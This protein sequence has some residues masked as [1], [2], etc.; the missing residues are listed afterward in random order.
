MNKNLAVWTISV[1]ILFITI[2]GALATDQFCGNTTQTLFT[3]VEYANGSM[4][5]SSTVTYTLWNGSV[6]NATNQGNGY[7]NISITTPAYGASNSYFYN[8]SSTNPTA[9]LVD[10][11]YVTNCTLQPVSQTIRWSITPNS[12]IYY[13]NQTNASCN[14]DLFRNN[15]NVAVLENNIYTILPIGTHNYSCQLQGN[16]TLLYA[17]HNETYTVLEVPAPTTGSSYTWPVANCTYGLDKSLYYLNDTITITFSCPQYYLQTYTVSWNDNKGVM[18]H[19]EQEVVLGSNSVTYTPLQPMKGIATVKAGSK[20]LFTLHFEV[21]S[22]MAKN[23][24]YLYMLLLGL[25]GIAFIY[26]LDLFIK[27]DQTGRGVLSTARD[28]IIAILVGVCAL[29][30]VGF[31]LYNSGRI[32]YVYMVVIASVIFILLMWLNSLITKGGKNGNG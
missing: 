6:I 27:H 28:K 11:L 29:I 25:A 2:L 13:G 4:A 22:E 9:S 3:Y 21:Q 20:I 16:A 23:I 8:V 24:G 15:I 30:G 31:Y 5:L 26:Y 1:F 12:P 7:Y 32:G 18:Y 10:Q 17:E 19:T 14:G